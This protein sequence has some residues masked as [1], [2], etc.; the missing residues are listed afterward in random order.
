MHVRSRQV[1]N[2]LV[3]RMLKCGAKRRWFLLPVKKLDL[4]GEVMTA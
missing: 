2:V 1:I 4:S 3:A